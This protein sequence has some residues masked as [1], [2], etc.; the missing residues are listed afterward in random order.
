VS[1]SWCCAVSI[2]ALSFLTGTAGAA[3]LTFNDVITGQISYSF[4]GDGDGANDVTF[5]TTDPG[6]F[7]AVGPGLNQNF[8]QEPGLEG[9]SLLDPDLRVDFLVGAMGPLSFAFAL[10]SI[11]EGPGTFASFEVYDAGNNLLGNSVVPGDFTVT[12]AGMS[13]FPEGVV[14][15]N[16]AGTVAYGFFNFQSDGGR[17]IIDNFEGTFGTSE[18]PEPWSPL[19]LSVG[20]IAMTF[21]RRAL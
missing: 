8:I 6:G 18:I 10:L 15:V 20:L 14:T 5:S 7:N 4:D 11:A 2:A 17:Y 16:F 19:L 1:T 13:S 12:P 9:T 21:V 3:V